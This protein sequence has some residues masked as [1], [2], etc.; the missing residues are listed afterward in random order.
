KKNLIDHGGLVLPTSSVHLIF[1][2]AW[3]GS[4][5]PDALE[6]FFTGFGG[7]SYANIM[8]QYMRD[9]STAPAVN[10]VVEAPDNSTPPAHPPSTSTIVAEACNAVG[11]NRPDPDGVYFVITSNFPKQSSFCAWH[12]DGICNGF[13]IAVTYLP[14]VTGVNGCGIPLTVNNGFS[15]GAQA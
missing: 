6:E 3:G 1:W 4:D 13:P 2:G 14:N 12:D 5:V 10:L 15:V 9:G 8:T 11:G 7:S